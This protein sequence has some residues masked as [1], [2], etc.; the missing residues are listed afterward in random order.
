MVKILDIDDALLKKIARFPILWEEL[1]H[2]SLDLPTFPPNGVSS[3]FYHLFKT[4]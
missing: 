4:V 3:C 1:F 2:Q